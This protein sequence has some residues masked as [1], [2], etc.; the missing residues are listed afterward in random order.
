MQ[1]I[2][3]S[4]GRFLSSLVLKDLNLENGQE[5]VLGDTIPY[6]FLDVNS[7]ADLIYLAS[8]KCYYAVTVHQV[9]E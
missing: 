6:T 3:F 1:R 7:H 2:V 8:E 9:E 4:S 5:T